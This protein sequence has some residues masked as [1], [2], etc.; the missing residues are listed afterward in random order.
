MG[1]GLSRRWG[2]SRCRGCRSCFCCCC[3]CCCCCCACRCFFFWCFR[4]FAP[5]FRIQPLHLRAVLL[6]VSCAFA[7]ALQQLFVDYPVVMASKDERGSSS[8]GRQSLRCELL[9]AAADV[10]SHIVRQ[11]VPLKA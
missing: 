6:L 11:A 2:C 9:A 7:S 10:K 1:G 5:C 3:C 4:F 8:K